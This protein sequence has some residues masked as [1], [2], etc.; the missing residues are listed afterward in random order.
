MMP[1]KKSVFLLALIHLSKFINST[2]VNAKI[3]APII[4][5]SRDVVKLILSIYN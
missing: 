3:S 2:I 4:I 1:P 5:L